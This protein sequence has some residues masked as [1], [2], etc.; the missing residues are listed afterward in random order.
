MSCRY[1]VVFVYVRRKKQYPNFLSFSSRLKSIFLFFST[2]GKSCDENLRKI[3]VTEIEL[4]KNN[5][6]LIT[7]KRT[8]ET[9]Q[10]ISNPS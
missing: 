3:E 5:S 7:D 1:C 4:Y 6:R 10:Y 8:S 2:F 9:I